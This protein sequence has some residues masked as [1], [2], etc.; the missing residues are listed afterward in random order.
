MQQVLHLSGDHLH[1]R[2]LPDPEA[3]LLGELPWGKFDELLTPAYWAAQSWMWE[4]DEPQHFR[5]GRGID[6]ELLACLLGGYGIPAEVGLAAY[7]RLRPYVDTGHL[8][9]VNWLRDMLS[10]PLEV[11]GR[12]VRYRFANQKAKY[13]AGAFSRLSREIEL[14]DDRP[15]REAL[16]ELPGIGPKTASWIVRNVR[17]SDRVAILDIHILWAGRALGIFPSDWKVETRYAELEDRFLGFAAAIDARASILD[18][19]MWMTVRRLPRCMRQEPLD[20]E[21]RTR[22]SECAREFGAGASLSC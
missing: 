8:T 3:P 10:E 4:L 11:H 7:E 17:G 6:E 16:M 18:S 5:L 21:A 15:L 9:R 20:A 12:S 2:S 14:L 13:V 22:Q 1:C 19:V